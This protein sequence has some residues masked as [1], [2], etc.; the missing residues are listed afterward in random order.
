[1]LATVTFWPKSPYVDHTSGARM[2]SMFHSMAATSSVF[3]T[4]GILADQS[5]TTLATSRRAATA[6]RVAA[7]DW[8]RIA[9]MIQNGLNE[10]FLWRSRARSSLW[11][12]PATDCSRFT[13]NHPRVVQ[14]W[15]ELAAD[16]SAPLCR[17][18]Q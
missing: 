10:T 9:L 5:G 7:P 1:M 6:L 18:A 4:F 14:P 12:E 13:T 2:R 16:R 8:I 15:I 3:W 11:L 17:M